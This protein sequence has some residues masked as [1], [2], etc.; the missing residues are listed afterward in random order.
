MRRR[1]LPFSVGAAVVAV[2]VAWVATRESRVRGADSGGPHEG[3]GAQPLGVRPQ[4]LAA[5]APEERRSATASTGRCSIVG[6]VRRD[7]V[8]VPASVTARFLETPERW[9][10]RS[11]L[12]E[13]VFTALSLRRDAPSPSSPA[14]RAG[15]DGRFEIGG[16]AS[17]RYVVSA[18]A[19]DGASGEASAMPPVE[20]AQVAAHVDVAPRRETLRIH[21]VRADGRPWKGALRVERTP[22]RRT[23]PFEP[24]SAAA[25]T[26]DT[27]R[28]V[29][30]G[31]APGP[32]VVLAL[33]ENVALVV[34][35]RIEVPHPGEYTLTIDAPE[36]EAA[37][38]V[39]A[40]DGS[41]VAGA[42]VVAT[43]RN[44]RRVV[45]DA[46]GRFRIPLDG[47]EGQ[48][49]AQAPGFAMDLVERVTAGEEVEIRLDRS[50]PLGTVSGHVTDPSGR[51][52]A[53]VAVHLSM[54]AEGGDNYWTLSTAVSDADG[55]YSLPGVQVGA[56]AVFALGGGWISQGFV[57]PPG[58]GRNPFLVTVA[59]GT[60]ATHDLVVVPGAR[61]AGH[62]VSA[63]GT[64]VGGA[65]VNADGYTPREADDRRFDPA[66]YA[67]REHSVATGA[68]GS[69]SI[70]SLVP[71]V[72][73][74]LTADAAGSPTGEVDGVVA[75]A[76]DGGDVEIRLVPSRSLDVTVVD[77]RTGRPLP[78][79][80]V[81]VR[82]SGRQEGSGRSPSGS[83]YAERATDG[84]GRVRVDGLGEGALS[85]SAAADGYADTNRT[86]DVEGSEARAD[87][88]AVTVRLD[89]G[90]RVAGR[91]VMPDGS[92]AAGATVRLH[93]RNEGSGGEGSSERADATG[94]FSFENVADG[95]LTLDASL[96]RE[97]G[98]ASAE[99]PVA[100]GQTDV[101]LRLE[102][103]RQLIVKVF[104][105]DGRPVPHA[106][107][108][109]QGRGA[110]C[111][112]GRAVFDELEGDE[113]GRIEVT[114]AKDADGARLPYGRATLEGA[115]AG[116]TYEI[117]LPPEFAI[118]GRVAGPDG[119]GVVGVAVR[120]DVV[121]TPEGE[122]EPRDE[123]WMWRYGDPHVVHT[124]EKGMFRVGS[125]G[126]GEH[127][128]FF[129][130]PPALVP[131]E[132][133]KALA[134]AT[135]IEVRLRDAVAPRMTVLDSKGAPIAGARVVAARTPVNE[136][137]MS[138]L[139]DPFGASPSLTRPDG[140]VVL[141][142]LDPG[143][144]YVLAVRP[145]DSRADLADSVDPRWSPRDTTVRM[146][147]GLVVAGVVLGSDGKAMERVRVT[148]TAG[149]GVS[150]SSLTL[151]DGAFRFTGL[152]PGEVRLSAAFWEAREAFGNEWRTAEARVLAGSERVGLTIDLGAELAVRVENWAERS[153]TRGATALLFDGSGEKIREALV[154]ADGGVLFGGLSKDDIC[155]MWIA[156]DD[157]G[158]S[159]RA[160]GL[161]PGAEE[162]S[163]RLALGKT[164]TVRFAVPRG[165][166]PV[167]VRAEALGVVAEGVRTAD[168]VYEVRGLPAG[169]WRIVATTRKE[170]ERMEAQADAPA[171]GEVTLEWKASK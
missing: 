22:S 75:S 12:Y 13:E 78:G 46:D 21:V 71:G 62:V 64:P 31:L 130:P 51:A 87:G 119:R 158:R 126:A 133:M 91:V 53:G 131:P 116:G 86:T 118:E 4:E 72:A 81:E 63:S 153:G 36:S 139:F 93:R 25:L 108:R 56:W 142:G 27:G 110:S 30:T 48:L 88:L 20:G 103:A 73:Y 102:A 137:T 65:V 117:R 161:R 95:R 111:E 44:V 9:R 141:A 128:L 109:F 38:R 168:G 39:L 80:R 57:S 6:T 84:S 76:G 85:A 11:R 152:R 10:Q 67:G 113:V 70:D 157:A 18:V 135:G 167:A 96:P 162:A 166:G 92:P 165:A 164:I 43:G 89:P 77:A 55:R 129:R 33:E 66:A 104:D 105:G 100:P 149:D 146:T 60:E 37:G 17:G 170:G 19:E 94:A 145:P 14:T 125:L 74:G 156:P 16:L 124:D 49:W 132:P 23:G 159:V 122:D 101:V 61:I 28:F 134:G 115:K 79:A 82:W 83:S 52:V 163:A 34:S 5:K 140:T 97:G 106:R 169:R 144:S 150:A 155:A 42:E 54:S 143:A 123:P 112:D 7:G 24:L 45:T 32:V 69:F 3:E 138:D 15:P 114:E 120:A 35:E 1:W 171:G 58:D 147:A 151:A 8:P 121:D 136:P 29:A 50:K 40:A 127:R 99:M 98:G 59:A 41:P 2:V 47:G 154:S 68:D 26:D 148:W 160:T 107:V 90:S